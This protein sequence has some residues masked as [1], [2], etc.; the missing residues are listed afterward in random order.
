MLPLRIRMARDD[1]GPRLRLE[2]EWRGIT[3]EQ[4]AAATKVSVELWEA[5]E[6]NDFSRW[7]RGVFARAFVRDYARAVGLD[8]DGV[9]NEF[10]RYFPNGDR[11]ASR[12]VK[13]QAA[14]IGHKLDANDAEL[15][16]AGRERRHAPRPKPSRSPAPAVYAPRLAA[17]TID[18]ACVS[19]VSLAVS[20]ISSAGLLAA[21]GVS[22]TL[23]FAGSIVALGTSPGLRILEALKLRAPTLFTSRR[24]VNA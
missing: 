3:L 21:L 11:R 19:I 24:T 22:A 20:A 6:R 10:C 17:A 2:R 1:F 15:L 8:A 4:L 16:P 23:Y 12:I 13:G 18:L 7:P 14:L 5:M 9:V